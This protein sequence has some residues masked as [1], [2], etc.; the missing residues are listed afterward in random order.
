MVLAF[1]E[2]GL[3]SGRASSSSSS[4][5]SVRARLAPVFGCAE[6][7]FAFDLGFVLDFGFVVDG[8]AAGAGAVASVVEL[9]LAC[10]FTRALARDGAAGLSA[11][12]FLRG[13]MFVQRVWRG[14]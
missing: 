13:G 5:E 6:G 3:S 12:A 8:A 4:S 7:G 10:A 9:V 1:L 2:T 14:G 11:E